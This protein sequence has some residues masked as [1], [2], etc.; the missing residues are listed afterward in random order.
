TGGLFSAD[1]DLSS[2][3]FQI[4]WGGIDQRNSFEPG[5]VGVRRLL[6]KMFFGPGGTPLPGV[7]TPLPHSAPNVA[8]APFY[9]APYFPFLNFL[10]PPIGPIR[11]GDRRTISP[12]AYPGAPGVIGPNAAFFFPQF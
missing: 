8:T 10:P 1:R 12:N 6:P 3:G 2:N 11:P 4:P 7:N 5:S 9:K